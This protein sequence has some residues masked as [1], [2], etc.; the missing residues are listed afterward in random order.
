MN[1]GIYSVGTFL[2]EHIRTNDFWPK[3]SVAKWAA[4]HGSTVD[5]ASAGSDEEETETAQIILKHMSQYRNDPFRGAV[6]RRV[7]AENMKTTDMEIEAA[8]QAIA[9]ANIDPASIDLLLTSTN[10]PD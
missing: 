7:M 8:K 9:R 1:V 10:L 5:R 6:E 2:P 4:H 3:D